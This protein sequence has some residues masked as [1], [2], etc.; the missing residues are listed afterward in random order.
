MSEERKRILKLIEEGMITA[1]E[2][3]ELLDALENAEKAKSAHVDQSLSEQV[4]WED[5]SHASDNNK[6]KKK[7]TKHKLFDFVDNTIHKIKNVDL[8]FNF[9]SSVSVS[10]IFQYQDFAFSNLDFEIENGS[11]D[12]NV[13][14]EREV[15]VECNAKVYKVEDEEAAKKQFLEQLQVDFQ[16]STFFIK[17]ETKKIKVDFIIYVP[18]QIYQKAAFKTFNGPIFLDSIESKYVNVK[19]TNG[20]ISFQKVK[21]EE[22]EVKSANSSVK[23]ENCVCSDCNVETINGSIYVDGTFDKIDSQLVNGSIHCFW[24]GMAGHTGFFKTT[25]GSVHLYVPGNKRIDGELK[26]SVG[27]VHCTLPDYETVKHTSDFLKKQLHFQ[28]EG[29][30]EKALY[31]EAET[32]TGSVNVHPLP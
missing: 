13:W 28:T 23:L 31:I 27:N 1:E 10:H 30:N 3:D 29:I 7:S 11:L 20:K 5:S 32:K 14:D 24:H 18:K 9:G 16:N 19:T 26:T 4:L 2:A 8:D 15:R 12:I 25:T 22:W 17:L 6:Q 21:G